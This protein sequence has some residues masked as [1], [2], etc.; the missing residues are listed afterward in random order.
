MDASTPSLDHHA[1]HMASVYATIS[2][3][4]IPV[5]HAHVHTIDS[6]KYDRNKCLQAKAE[7]ETQIAQTHQTIPR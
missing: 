7:M 5:H 4:N 3:D 6:Y 2:I 1:R